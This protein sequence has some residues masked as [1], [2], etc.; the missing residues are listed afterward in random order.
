MKRPRRGYR[1]QAPI[2]SALR[3]A[4]EYCRWI[5]EWETW[6]RANVIAKWRTNAKAFGPQARSRDGS[7]IEANLAELRSQLIRTYDPSPTLEIVG[8][9]VDRGN[10][11]DFARLVPL[12]FRKQSP[13]T[14]LLIDEYRRANLNRITSLG[15]DEIL[16]LRQILEDAEVAPGGTRVETLAKTIHERLDVTKSKATLLARD[17]TLKLGG[18][19]TRLRQTQAGIDKFEWSTSGDERVRPEHEELD[20]EIFAWDDPPDAGDGPAVPGEDYQCR[21]IALPILP[22]DESY[23]EDEE[24]WADDEEAE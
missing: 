15:A 2:A 20:G 14:G 24:E 3:L 23:D 21:C 10:A 22:D 16:E 1:P 4:Q 6:L 7:W 9:R 19:L 12:S 5:D 8:A 17:Q 13:S 18:Q 11:R